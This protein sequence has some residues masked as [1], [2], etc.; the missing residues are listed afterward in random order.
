MTLV[1][2][3]TVKAVPST[4]DVVRSTAQTES[5]KAGNALIVLVLDPYQLRYDPSVGSD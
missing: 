5:I 2:V 4:S 1:L 3:E